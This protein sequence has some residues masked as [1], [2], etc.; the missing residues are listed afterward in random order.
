MVVHPALG[1]ARAWATV[2][3]PLAG[4]GETTE[5]VG[6]CGRVG[7]AAGGSRRVCVSPGGVGVSV[8]ERTGDGMDWIRLLKAQG[9]NGKEKRSRKKIK[10][11]KINTQ[12]TF[13]R[14]C[15]VSESFLRDGKQTKPTF[16]N[17]KIPIISVY[18]GRARSPVQ[19]CDVRSET[20]GRD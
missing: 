4:Y 17:G 16:R 1:A 20:D 3:G 6:W 10:F 8:T 14:M 13:Q 19:V 9:Q 12:R 11:D 18:G 5:E 7:A 15:L 2:P